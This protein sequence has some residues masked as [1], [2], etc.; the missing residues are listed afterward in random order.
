M[1]LGLAV[2]AA[3]VVGAGLAF[4][5]RAASA[6]LDTGVVDVTTNLAYQNGSAAGTGMVLTSSGDVLTNNHVIRGA[7]TVRVVDPST[8][9]S[10]AATVVGYSVSSDIALLKIRGA[11]HLRTVTLGDSS[12]VRV[13]QRVTAIGNAG[14]AGGK[15]SSAT[16][17]VTGLGRT[18]VASDGG[19]LSER[20]VG[21]IRTNAALEPGDSGGPL[22]NTAGRVIGIDTAAS[23]GF[24]FQSLHD[25][26]A[27]PI[28]RALAIV[29]QIRAG[30]AS[31]TVHIGSTPFL[32]LSVAFAPSDQNG[33]GAGVAAVVP[34][35]PAAQAGIVAGNTITTLDG[36]AVTSYAA[37]TKLLLRHNAGDT[38]MLEWVDATGAT[39]SASV[40]TAAGPPQ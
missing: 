19:G 28:N 9:R 40:R 6:S 7:T 22:L 14:G 39:Q 16:G 18:I 3:A 33:S 20:L 31:A 15:P 37:L 8:G 21:L 36:Q 35:S 23:A 5:P 25:G 26:Y 32:G 27:I 17:T 29:R 13:G 2:A 24:Q 11:S 4:A 38:V 10:Y 1:L 12:A 34:G 30:R